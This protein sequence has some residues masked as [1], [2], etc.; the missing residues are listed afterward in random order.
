MGV[1]SKNELFRVFENKNFVESPTYPWVNF[2]PKDIRDRDVVASAKFRTKGRFPSLTYYDAK[3]G[4]SLWRSSQT[5]IGIIHSRCLSDENFL[6]KIGETNLANPRVKIFDAR[7]YLNAFANRA[8]N[9]GFENCKDYY[10]SCEIK[11]C[12]IANIHAVN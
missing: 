11:F 8:K 9:G 5:K 3:T 12:E 7:P 1:N 10:T 2:V 6:N 4:T